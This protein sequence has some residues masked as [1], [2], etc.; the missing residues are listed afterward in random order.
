MRMRIPKAKPAFAPPVIPGLVVP[1]VG[2]DVVA[3][4]CVA[5]VGDGVMAAD[6]VLE[7]VGL[8]EDEVVGALPSDK[9]E[10]L[11]RPSD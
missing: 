8:D 6:G 7:V 5:G 3:G 10:R 2:V 4:A 1:V 11:S 9:L